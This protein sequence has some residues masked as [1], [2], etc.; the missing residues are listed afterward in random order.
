[1]NKSLREYTCIA[2]R[3]EA[4]N[5]EESS[6]QPILEVEGLELKQ[7]GKTILEVPQLVVNREQHC[8]IE[9]SVLVYMLR[10]RKRFTV[11]SGP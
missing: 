7:D 5:Q 4:L 6:L 8:F 3:Q 1:M 10:F 2:T 9:V 11:F